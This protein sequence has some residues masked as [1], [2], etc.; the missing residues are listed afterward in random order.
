MDPHPVA[1]PDL[2]H[3]F[4]GAR[5]PAAVE[6]VPVHDALSPRRSCNGAR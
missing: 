6:A 2:L 1:R 4:L 3:G 5:H